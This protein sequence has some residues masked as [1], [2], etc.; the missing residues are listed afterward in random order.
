MPMTPYG[1]LVNQPPIVSQSGTTISSGFTTDES[2]IANPY[3]SE[4][5]NVSYDLFG[6]MGNI[7][8]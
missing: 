1:V 2:T 7:R 4:Y 8:A 6:R 3:Y 5:A